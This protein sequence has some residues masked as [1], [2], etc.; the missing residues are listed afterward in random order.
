[1]TVTVV[2][3]LSA[4][5]GLGLHVLESFRLVSPLVHKESGCELYAAHLEQGGDAVVMVERWSTREDLDAHAN[6]AALRKL[7]E[8]NAGLLTKPYDVWFLDEVP[9]GEKGK[10]LIPR[11][12]TSL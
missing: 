4:K 7:N 5:S 10:G 2:A 8:L 3:I 6:G 12:G 11:L 9:L 1:M